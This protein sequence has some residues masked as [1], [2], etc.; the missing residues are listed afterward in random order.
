MLLQ[1]LRFAVRNLRKSPAF[2]LAAIAT[3]ALGIGATTAIFSTVNAALLRPLPYPKPNDLFA[4]RTTLTDGRVT[5][6]L[7]SPAEIAR[8]NNPNLSIA[9]AGG[10]QQQ[11]VTLLRDDNTPVKASVYIINDAFFDV[12]G[13][14]MTLGT[15]PPAAVNQ[16]TPP[17][18]IISARVW[19]DLYSSDPNVVGKPIRF[20]EARTTIAAV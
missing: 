19:H 14:P 4:I 10:M 11:D 16:N 15:V 3:L 12:S 17:P 9:R 5:T 13:L 18:V 8:L 20:L 1:D 7:L 2:A 6:G